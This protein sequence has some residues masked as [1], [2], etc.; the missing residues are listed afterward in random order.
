MSDDDLAEIRR[1]K[2]ERLRQMAKEPVVREPLAN[3][4]VNL[5]TDSN[6][7]ETVQKTKTAMVD[8]FGTWCNP[9]KALAPILQQLAQ[10]YKRDVFFA[11]ID[12]DRNPRTTAQFGVQSVPMVVIFKNGKPAG[13]IPGLRRYAEY[14]M[15][16]QRLLES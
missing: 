16:I 12:I 5:L 1:R 2:I 3:G 6:F 8:F 13:N 15:V 9:C 7:W 4:S 14:D 11:K 10:D